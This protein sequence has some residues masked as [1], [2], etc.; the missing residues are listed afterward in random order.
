[1]SVCYLLLGCFICNLKPRKD[2]NC[3][4]VPPRAVISK[5]WGAPPEGA[6][7]HLGDMVV[8]GQILQGA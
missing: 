6:E 2:T 8:P 1:M 3:A 7:K 5:L 4:T